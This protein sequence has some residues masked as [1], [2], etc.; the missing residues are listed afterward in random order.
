MSCAAPDPRLFDC[1]ND[2]GVY[3][4]TAPLRAEFCIAGDQSDVRTRLEIK[5]A[6]ESCAIGEDGVARLRIVEP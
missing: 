2:N 1:P 6:L 4:G 3:Y 5:T